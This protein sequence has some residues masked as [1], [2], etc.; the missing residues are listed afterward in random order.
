MFADLKVPLLDGDASVHELYAAGGA[1]VPVVERMFPDA[2][3]GGA[4]TAPGVWCTAGCLWR[5]SASGGSRVPWRS[6]GQCAL[7]LAGDCLGDRSIQASRWLPAR[8]AQVVAAQP[9]ASA[10]SCGSLRGAARLDRRAARMSAWRAQDLPGPATA[11]AHHVSVAF[12]LPLCKDRCSWSRPG[13]CDAATRP[14]LRGCQ[15][16]QHV[17]QRCCQPQSDLYPHRCAQARSTKRS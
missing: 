8:C 3:S 2:V 12:V 14:L 15:H 9:V 4:H 7:Q 10:H 16:K 1:A 6:A 17:L 13:P 5:R 11:H